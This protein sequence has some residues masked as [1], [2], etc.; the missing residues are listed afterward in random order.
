MY[1]PIKSIY[2]SVF[3]ESCTCLAILFLCRT[4]HTTYASRKASKVTLVRDARYWTPANCTSQYEKPSSVTPIA[5]LLSI[6]SPSLG[7][8]VVK[9]R[10]TPRRVLGKLVLRVGTNSMILNDRTIIST[11]GSHRVQVIRCK[12][13]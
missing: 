9:G 4:H 5:K 1:R 3:E 13:K 10:A 7:S 6:Q 8:D 2:L 11:D 12:G